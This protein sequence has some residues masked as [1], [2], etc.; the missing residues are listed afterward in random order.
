VWLRRYGDVAELDAAD[1]APGPSMGSLQ[2]RGAKY[3]RAS[4]PKMDFIR[5]CGIVPLR[6]DPAFTAL[7]WFGPFEEHAT[8]VVEEAAEPPVGKE[9]AVAEESQNKGEL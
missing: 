8:P 9:K 6:Y 5:T 1:D 2:A 3:A 4:F 7:E